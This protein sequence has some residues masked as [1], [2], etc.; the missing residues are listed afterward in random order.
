MRIYKQNNDNDC[1]I[2][3]TQSLI[4]HF[5]GEEVSREELCSKANL[6]EEGLSILDLEILNKHYGIALESYEMDFE[7]FQKYETP[8]CFILLIKSN[9]LYHYVIAQKNSSGVTLFDSS[10]GRISIKYPEFKDLYLNVFITIHCD[11]KACPLLKKAERQSSLYDLETIRTSALIDL[12]IF[13]LTLIIGFST[14][15]GFNHIVNNYPITQ[16]GG[17][18]ILLVAS[19]G[20]INFGEYIKKCLVLK[21]KEHYSKLL[22][23]KLINSFQW[24]KNSFFQ[25]SGKDQILLIR[26]YIDNIASY[27]S[28]Y[29]NKWI[30]NLII[31]LGLSVF[32]ACIHPLF[33]GLIALSFT[34]KL[35]HLRLLF[36]EHRSNIPKLLSVQNESKKSNYD[37]YEFLKKE[38]NV[39]KLSSLGYAF[40]E[41]FLKEL[42]LNQKINSRKDLISGVLGFCNN[43]LQLLLYLTLAYLLFNK[44]ISFGYFII[45]ALFYSQI[46]QSI[47]HL[48]DFY[49]FRTTY[50]YSR[51]IYFHLLNTDSIE[52]TKEEWS[53]PSEITINHLNY[54]HS[55]SIIFNNLNLKIP[56]NTFLSGNSGTGKT[57]LYHLISNKIST[58]PNH[59]FFDE[60]SHESLENKGFHKQIIY[61]PSDSWTGNVDI[62]KCLSPLCLDEKKVLL[63]ICEQMNLPILGE[64]D[65]RRVSSGQ[66]QLLNLIN[67]IPYSKKILLLDEVTSHINYLHRLEIFKKLFPILMRNNFLIC[68]EHEVEFNAYF[69]HHINLNDHIT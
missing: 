59:I 27:Y 39:E 44:S 64:V 65:S 69:P 61:Q 50:L 43:L 29:V 19:Y 45:I 30:L 48:I 21:N 20:I 3:V 16:L 54:F 15:Y 42:I 33:L 41:S 23:Q 25:K 35:G 5:Y 7:E 67:L 68:S 11:K 37:F 31:L 2:S 46:S 36:E 14:Q 52:R 9:N 56:R 22:F 10:F 24:K 34:I 6:N 58:L 66:R 60:E 17:I 55:D 47:S 40:K 62:S 8:E 1:G 38:S 26:N 57:T 4:Y 32:L 12:A 53:L 51:N 18:T 49:F 28:E 63:D 13:A